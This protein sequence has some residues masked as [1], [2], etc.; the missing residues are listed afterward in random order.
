MKIVT[1]YCVFLLDSLS[2]TSIL[3]YKRK[4]TVTVETLKFF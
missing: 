4:V 3:V 1:I 2:T